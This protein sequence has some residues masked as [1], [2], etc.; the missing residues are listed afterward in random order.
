MIL[1]LCWQ[2][3]NLTDVPCERCCING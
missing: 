1:L 3:I 2:F